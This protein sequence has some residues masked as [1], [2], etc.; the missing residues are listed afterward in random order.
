MGPVRRITPE[1]GFPET[2]G[3]GQVYGTPW[4]FSEDF[5]LCVYDEGMQPG[6]ASRAGRCCAA[7]TA[8]T[9]STAFGNRELIYRDPEIS[10]LSPIPL[11]SRPHAA[12]RSGTGEAQPDSE[13]GGAPPVRS[14]GR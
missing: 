11:R 10:C 6:P 13:S 9:W 4:P 5:Y 12:G 2:Q 14:L 7:T 3:G 1:V 8:S